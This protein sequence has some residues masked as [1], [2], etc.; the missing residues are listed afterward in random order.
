[1]R[2]AAAYHGFPIPSRSFDAS[3]IHRYRYHH[4]RERHRL[5]GLGVD[6][7]LLRDLAEQLMFGDEFVLAVG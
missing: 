3:G 1:M 6:R 5:L 4:H 7:D 2:S